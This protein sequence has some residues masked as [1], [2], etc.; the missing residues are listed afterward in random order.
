MRP[1][2]QFRPGYDDPSCGLCATLR[3][4]VLGAISWGSHA[5]SVFTPS[6]FCPVGWLFTEGLSLQRGVH[7]AEASSDLGTVPKAIS[8]TS[9]V[10]NNQHSFFGM[11]KGLFR[12]AESV[13]FL[14]ST[15]TEVAWLP[16]RRIQ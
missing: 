5:R 13:C 14:S 8:D 6:C 7:P 3:R 9:I 1:G 2:V 16:E 15:A 12:K 4:H 11:R 10:S